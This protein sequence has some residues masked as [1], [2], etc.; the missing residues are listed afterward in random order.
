[1][2]YSI[3]QKNIIKELVHKEHATAEEIARELQI[4]EKT[5]RKEIKEINRINGE[6]VLFPVKGKGFRIDEK[7]INDALMGV[8]SYDRKKEFLK[9]ILVKDKVDYYELAD[10]Y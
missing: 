8:D 10:N 2:G 7:E 9:E 3:R 4:S 1:M 5:V 6:T